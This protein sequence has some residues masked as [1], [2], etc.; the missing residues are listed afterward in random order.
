MGIYVKN[1]FIKAKE[2]G[3]IEIP[4]QSV[5]ERCEVVAVNDKLS[6]L[7]DLELLD[8]EYSF[9][10]N[11]IYNNESIIENNL[12]KFILQPM[13]LLHELQASLKMI[14]AFKV[15]VNQTNDKGIINK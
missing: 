12:A 15:T 1:K 5:F 2:N 4:F 3:E 11:L 14:T 10:C 13:L 9:K 6:Q 7:V 8:E